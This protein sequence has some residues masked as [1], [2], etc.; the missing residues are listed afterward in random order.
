MTPLS[1]ALV[2]RKARE[3]GI[4]LFLVHPTNTAALLPPAHF[5]TVP[6]DTQQIRG[7][8]ESYLI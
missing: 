7:S 6:E 8:R 2:D 4:T 3:R 5:G 1:R